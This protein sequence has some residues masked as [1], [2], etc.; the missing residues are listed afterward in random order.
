MTEDEMVGWHHPL[1]GDEFE[2]TPG[3]GEGQ[4][5]LAS[6]SLWGNKE[7]NSTQ[8][9]NNHRR[10]EEIKAKK[11]SCI[12]I[13]AWFEGEAES[14]REDE[15]KDGLRGTFIVLFKFDFLDLSVGVEVCVIF[16]ICYLY[17]YIY[18]YIDTHLCFQNS[19][20]IESNYK[21]MFPQFL[22]T[23]HVF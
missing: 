10:S 15:I 12:T 23:S 9:L 13:T 17:V 18:M 20:K 3:D 7:S 4:Q 14:R 6:C 8:L 5:S 11:F 22:V 19:I 1:N 2:Q 16:V 21:Q